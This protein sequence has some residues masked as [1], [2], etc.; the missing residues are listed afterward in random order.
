[1]LD[2]QQNKTLKKIVSPSITDEVINQLLNAIRSDVFVPGEKLPSEPA[3]ANQLGVSR[4]TLREALNSLIEKGYLFRQRGVGTFVTPQSG[5]MLN[6][7]LA[8]VVGTSSLIKNQKKTPGQADF[9]YQFEPATK[10]VAE[11]LQIAESDQ[12][13]HI[14]RVR[15][16][17]G[18]P[19]IQSEEYIPG[20]IPGLDY[21]F[22]KYAKMDNWSIYDYLK[23]YDYAIRSTIT[24]VHAIAA[25]KELAKK[26]DVDENAP[27]LCLVQTQFTNKYMKPLLFC[28]NYHNDKIINIMLVRTE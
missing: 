16:A 24:H 28:K 25:D 3:L 7:N 8:N 10:E 20:D 15:T 2:N 14:S 5:V 4:N 12:V 18:I 11:S 22:E 21:E 9:S 23:K 6:A 27:L 26:L 1:M 17:N 19:V 13:L